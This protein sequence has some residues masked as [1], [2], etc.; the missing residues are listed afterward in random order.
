M[1]TRPSGNAPCNASTA[2]DGRHGA[3]V[4]VTENRLG[5]ACLL[6]GEWKEK[7]GRSTRRVR[8]RKQ[9]QRVDTESNWRL[10]A[11]STAFV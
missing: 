11:T 4:K 7:K 8:K 5:H 3:Q 10:V 2:T 1:R 9:S 6:E